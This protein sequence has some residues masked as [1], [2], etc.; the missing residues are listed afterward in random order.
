MDG[1]GLGYHELKKLNPALVYA[2]ASGFGQTGPW[3]NKPAYDLQIQAMC[4]LMSITG[5]EGGSPT[6]AGPSIIDV[7]TGIE[8]AT[9]ITAALYSREKT[10]R[11]RRVDV[12]ML[13]VGVA[14]LEN[15]VTRYASTG[16]LPVQEGNRHASITPFDTFTAGDGMVFTLAV[17]GDRMW[18]TFCGAIARGDLEE[19]PRFCD[20]PARTANH[21]ELKRVLED[22]V[23]KSGG[24]KEW[25]ARFDEAGVPASLISGIDMIFHNPQVAA[26]DMLV[27]LDRPGTGGH[28]VAGNPIKISEAADA[29]ESPAP[30]LGEHTG[31]IL[32]DIAGITPDE[33]ARLMEKG[34]L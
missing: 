17:A 7:V 27:K 26:R 29:P 3:A 23:F 25:V 8:M 19:D 9:G 10:G 2:S 20:N 30:D 34:V 24:A 33:I 11:G 28:T 12:A 13:D 21:R 5:Q 4:G 15:A 18:R 22:E 1:L 32:R 31:E 14:I 6:K 16:T